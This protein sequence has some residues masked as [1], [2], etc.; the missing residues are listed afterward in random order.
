MLFHRFTAQIIGI[1]ALVLA[2]VF[3]YFQQSMRIRPPDILMIGDSQISFGSGGVF[4]DF[5]KEFDENCR[6]TPEQKN[7]LAKLDLGNFAAIGVRSSSLDTWTAK[8]T[9]GKAMICEIDRTWGVNAGVYGIKGNPK[10]QYVQIGQGEHYQFCR[11]NTSPF[12]AMFE[13]SYYQPKIVL[14]AFLGNSA[15]V[16]A[17]DQQAVNRDVKN[18]IAQLPE[19][20]MCI[21]MTT[22]PSYLGEINTMRQKAQAN[23]KGA[24]QSY[25]KQCSFVEG[26][27]TET[28]ESNTGNSNYF[29]TDGEGKVTDP[30]HPNIAA[31]KKFLSLKRDSLCSAMFEQ[32]AKFD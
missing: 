21:F 15:E 13:Q 8:D 29:A 6:P 12:E 23:L 17:A 28:R 22:A 25:G 18:T 2:A 14:L 31:Q 16:W 3:V 7:Q 20:A 4:Q 9:A 5:F 24:F 27:T 11:A 1:M 26:F 32:V 10:R 30:R 19:D